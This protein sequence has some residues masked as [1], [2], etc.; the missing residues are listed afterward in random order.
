MPRTSRSTPTMSQLYR[1]RMSIVRPDGAGLGSARATT[2]GAGVSMVVRSVPFSSSSSSSSFPSPAREGAPRFKLTPRS[3]FGSSESRPMH[4]SKASRAKQP[5]KQR[6]QSASPARRGP[7]SEM[8]NVQEVPDIET[9]MEEGGRG[10]LGTTTDALDE[11]LAIDASGEVVTGQ[12]NTDAL[13]FDQRPARCRSMAL[14]I[15]GSMRT[16]SDMEAL[17]GPVPILLQGG[18][19]IDQI[20]CLRTS[21]VQRSSSHPTSFYTSLM[22]AAGNSVV[23]GAKIF[24]AEL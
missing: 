16:R 20:E 15:H 8:P 4:M 18:E 3:K 24:S 22:I 9:M 2:T 19:G 12:L 11:I 17:A 5:V 1:E 21:W 7:D 6:S 13:R 14:W 23:R 10:A